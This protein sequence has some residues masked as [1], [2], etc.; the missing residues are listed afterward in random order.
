[1][2]DSIGRPATDKITGFSGI[3]TGR[4]E[5]IT[6]CNQVLVTPKQSEGGALQEPRWIDEQRCNISKFNNEKIAIENRENPG[7]DVPA[8][9]R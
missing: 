3:I 1:M 8:P 9:V 5:Y 2:H 7:F 4:C 6:G